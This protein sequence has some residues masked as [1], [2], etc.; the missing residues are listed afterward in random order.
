MEAIKHFSEN[1]DNEIL[2]ECHRVEAPISGPPAP[3]TSAECF[4]LVSFSLTFNAEPPPFLS[5]SVLDV[6][7]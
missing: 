7:S 5:P 1:F 2:R 4:A 3:S 6:P